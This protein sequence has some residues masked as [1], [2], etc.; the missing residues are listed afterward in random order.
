MPNPTDITTVRS[1]L[2]MVNYH[3]KFIPNLATITKP[4]RDLLKINENGPN[5]FCWNNLCCE[6]FKKIKHI[7]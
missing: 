1:L 3:L 5:T 6:A 2:G 4:I 7:Y